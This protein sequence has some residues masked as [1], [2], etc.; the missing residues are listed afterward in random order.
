VPIMGPA[1]YCLLNNHVE[2]NM[3]GLAA[4]LA[5]HLVTCEASHR[6]LTEVGLY[7]TDIQSAL[8]TIT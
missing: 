1:V 8:L 6:W 3:S 4:R 7:E 5:D 2:R